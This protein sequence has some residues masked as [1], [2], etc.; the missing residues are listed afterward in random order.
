MNCSSTFLEHDLANGF[1]ALALLTDLKDYNFIGLIKD[2]QVVEVGLV[3]GEVNNLRQHATSINVL[4][5]PE[6]EE[7]KTV[8]ALHYYGVR[9]RFHGSNLLEVLR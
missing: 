5:D 2:V 9:H 7:L 6:F 4:A 1:A 3:K 8:L